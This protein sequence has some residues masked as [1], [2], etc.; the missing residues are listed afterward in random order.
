[1][2]NK[3][4]KIITIFVI[5]VECV[6]ISQIAFANQV[7]FEIDTSIGKKTVVVPEGMTIEEAYC[8]MAK[9]YIE[10]KVDHEK[11]IAQ[12]QDLIEKAQQ[13]EEAS[14]KVIS[15]KETLIDYEK[16]LAELYKKL[17][18][19]PFVS[20]IV[21]LGATTSTFDKIDSV[22]LSAGVE[23]SDSFIVLAEAHYPWSFGLNFGM[24]F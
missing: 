22:S 5:I 9:L 14:Q 17:A 13:Y 3:F 7:S 21:L 23:V 11:L 8:E 12:T 1:M 4:K 2:L 18:K 20:P 15:L 6:C 19:R 10:E 24:R 16:K